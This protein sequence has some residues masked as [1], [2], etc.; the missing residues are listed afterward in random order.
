MRIPKSIIGTDNVYNAMRAM[1]LTVKKHSNII[2][3]VLCPGLGTATGQLN[4]EVAARQM[5]L[6]Y[7]SVTKP[8]RIINWPEAVKL[9]TIINQ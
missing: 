5:Y 4:P 9:D 2:E 8:Q 6:A 1:L 3:T 7:L